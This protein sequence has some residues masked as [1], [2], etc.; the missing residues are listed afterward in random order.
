M[1]LLHRNEAGKLI[2]SQFF[3]SNIPRYAILSHTWGADGEEVNFNDIGNDQARHKS[4]WTKLDFCEKQAI[5]DRLKYF[6]VDTCCIDKSSSAELTEDINSMFRYYQEAIK[7][8]VFLTDVSVEDSYGAP[9]W[10]DNAQRTA[11]RNSRWFSRGWT[12]QELIAPVSVQFFSVERVLLGD[13]K[14]LEMEVYSSTG[15]DAAALQGIHLSNFGATQKM[16]WASRRNTTREEDGAYCLLGIFDVSMP[17]IYGEGRDKAFRRLYREIEESLNGQGTSKHRRLEVITHDPLKVDIGRIREDLLESLFYIDHVARR[18]NVK[19]PWNNTF[20]W[21]FD[22]DLND[23]VYKHYYYNPS[24][25]GYVVMARLIG[26][27]A[28]RLEAGLE[29]WSGGRQIHMLS[30]FFWRAGSELQK[31]IV[32][33]LRSLLYQVVEEIPSSADTV[34]GAIRLAS[35]RIPV[36]TEEVL[37]KSLRAA[38]KAVPG[39]NFCLFID[40]LDEFEGDYDELLDL[41]FSLHSL[42]N[43]KCCLSSRPE[44]DLVARLMTCKQLRLQDLNRDD[45][46]QFIEEKLDAC[47]TN[48]ANKRERTGLVHSIVDGAEGVFLWAALV[49]TSVIK[50]LRAG[51]DENVIRQRVEATPPEME[52]LFAQMLASVDTFHKESLAFYLHILRRNNEPSQDSVALIAAAEYSGEITDYQLFVRRCETTKN[53]ILAR[54]KGLLEIERRTRHVYIDIGDFIWCVPQGEVDPQALESTTN[55]IRQRL[56]ERRSFVAYTPTHQELL[57]YTGVS[58]SFIHRSA[59]DFISNPEG[60]EAISSLSTTSAASFQAKIVQ[61]HFRLLVALPRFDL[62]GSTDLHGSTESI[63]SYASIIM[64]SISILVDSPS[65]R[66]RLLDELQDLMTHFPKEE[67][68]AQDNTFG[69]DFERFNPRSKLYQQ[70]LAHTNFWDVFRMNDKF[71]YLLYSLPKL[72]RLKCRTFIFWILIKGFR[73]QL[74]KIETPPKDVLGPVGI[75][76][77]ICEDQYKPEA[78][79][80]PSPYLYYVQTP[81]IAEFSKTVFPNMSWT[82]DNEAS[83]YYDDEI[84]WY[85]V[86]AYHDWS[87]FS[88]DEAKVFDDP[89]VAKHV[90]DIRDRFENISQSLDPHLGINGAPSRQWPL[91]FQLPAA[92]YIRN[93]PETSLFRRL[94][95]SVKKVSPKFRIVCTRTGCASRNTGGLISEFC[96]V[97]FYDLRPR[98]SIRLMDFL[99][100][101]KR[102]WAR[103]SPKCFRGS[104]QQYLE[105]QELVIDDVRDNVEQQLSAWEQLYTLACVKTKFLSLWT[106]LESDESNLIVSEGEESEDD[107]EA[108]GGSFETYLGIGSWMDVG[109]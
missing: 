36:W 99:R 3:G 51:D 1:R 48:P 29:I 57:N 94:A 37:A 50:G 4:G 61:A 84:I 86:K 43:V 62:F 34:A 77:R 22:D 16:E 17:L 106:I 104:W 38:L 18:Q 7:C 44:T 2:L 79:G 68:L 95:T 45:I 31:S 60:E 108:E 21:I 5:S 6:W 82:Y 46:H 96:L 72:K 47:S 28:R 76:L 91:F 65:Q 52:A 32:G 93:F 33:M 41:V 109:L 101:Q 13:K 63:R 39:H 105:C 64:N 92:A 107:E 97:A 40:G 75:I 100:I 55:E 30:F 25:T 70:S 26:S 27:T 74:T 14:S 66:Y 102:S 88:S 73:N 90:E 78:S 24:P 20:K 56:A 53:Q 42:D 12:L 11:F 71:E 10:S 49:V 85:I 9:F 83:L 80:S 81:E 15:I 58:V 19:P 54:G 98:V 35:G 59:Y 23:P 69:G 87:F 103:H 8:Y 89:I 67:F